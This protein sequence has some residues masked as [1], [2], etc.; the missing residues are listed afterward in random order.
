[1]FRAL[2]KL[3]QFRTRS[4][5]VHVLMAISFLCALGSAF[6]LSGQVGMVSF[7]AFLNFTAGLW[8]AQLVHSLGHAFEAAGH[9][10][11]VEQAT[12]ARR[13]GVFDEIAWERFL[14]IA[15][16]IAFAASVFVFTASEIL[17]SELSI[18]AVGA[19]GAIA[20]L[21]AIIGFLIAAAST[22]DH[23]EERASGANPPR[24]EREPRANDEA[25]STNEER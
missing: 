19:I 5:A 10:G 9:E 8:I 24:T 20:L 14:R 25:T 23:A 12:T 3:H 11:D 7:V 4:R 21:A 6:L 15:V 13:A 22:L 1:M 16:V 18:V 2:R 17:P